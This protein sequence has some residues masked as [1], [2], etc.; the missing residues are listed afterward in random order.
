MKAPAW[1]L[2][3]VGAVLGLTAGPFGIVIGSVLGGAG[4]V[5]RHG[6]RRKHVADHP[7]GEHQLRAV[8]PLAPHLSDEAL[9]YKAAVSRPTESALALHE[10]LEMFAAGRHKS[11]FWAHD[12]TR[13]RVAQ[14]QR[15]FNDDPGMRAGVHPLREDGAFDRRT[16]AALTLHTGVPVS[17]DPKAG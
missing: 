10:L 12:T 6:H 2:A 13:G 7:L 8:R 11:K 9:Q 17:P 5:L 14:F 3:M 16:A 4:D 1:G 15:S